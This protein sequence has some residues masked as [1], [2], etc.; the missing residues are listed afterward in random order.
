[1]SR[2]AFKSILSRE[3]AAGAAWEAVAEAPEVS[4]E[5]GIAYARTAAQTGHP[6]YIPTQGRATADQPLEYLLMKTAETVWAAASAAQ[7]D[8]S[9]YLVPVGNYMTAL[10]AKAGLSQARDFALGVLT[11][12]VRQE[13]DGWPNQPGDPSGRRTA[14]GTGNSHLCLLEVKHLV[15][16]AIYAIEAPELLAASIAPMFPQCH[17]IW[18]DLPC[19]D[20]RLQAAIRGVG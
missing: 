15:E 11:E 5:A 6:P 13:E 9:S 7:Q 1:V 16:I 12:R 20:H 14:H 3:A 17:C 10:A 2:R 19:C 18:S 8:L 4:M